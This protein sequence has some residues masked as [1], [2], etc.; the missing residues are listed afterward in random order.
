MVKLNIKELAKDFYKNRINLSLEETESLLSHIYEDRA[1]AEKKVD[2]FNPQPHYDNSKGSLY[3]IAKER[4]WNAYVF[5]AIKRLERAEKKGQFREDLQKTKDVI[6]IYL[7]E[8]DQ[9]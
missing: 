9:D 7:R 4:G 5:D 3:K 2:V 8:Y 6:D 1:E